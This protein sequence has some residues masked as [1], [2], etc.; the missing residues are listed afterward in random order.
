[1]TLFP[2]L[3]QF[4]LWEESRLFHFRMM[5][6]TNPRGTFPGG[7]SPAHWG[8]F[9]S[10]PTLSSAPYWQN[11]VSP[12]WARTDVVVPH[13][14]SGSET[15][16]SVGN[17][18]FSLW[19]RTRRGHGHARFRSSASRRRVLPVKSANRRKVSSRKAP[20]VHCSGSLD[21][22]GQP[23]GWSRV[24]FDVGRIKTVCN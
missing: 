22:E 14:G 21:L 7:L 19:R 11:S 6:A 20:L 4:Q 2:R 13:R 15:R 16:F 23:C 18:N 24:R 12:Y 10:F 5:E 3:L 9:K 8:A 17:I 1:M